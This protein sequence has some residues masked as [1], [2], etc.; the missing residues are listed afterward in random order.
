MNGFAA[1]SETAI[2]VEFPKLQR[3]IAQENSV[4]GF[5]DVWT[6]L[7]T[8]NGRSIDEAL[9]A[10]L[11]GELKG[12]SLTCDGCHPKDAGLTIMAETIAKAIRA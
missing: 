9:N 12:E 1:V 6:P 10:T 3:K 2:N 8:I 4:D 5:I 7:M 11:G